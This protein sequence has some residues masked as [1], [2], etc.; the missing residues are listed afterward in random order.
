MKNLK[1]LPSLVPSL[2]VQ[3]LALSGLVA[4]MLVA[5]K[6]AQAFDFS[7]KYNGKEYIVGG[8]VTSV[9]KTPKILG[10]T[11]WYGNENAAIEFARAG[12]RRVANVNGPTLK[13]AYL[14]TD[15]SWRDPKNEWSAKGPSVYN[16]PKVGSSTIVILWASSN[17]NFNGGPDVITGETHFGLK[18]DCQIGPPTT[19]KYPLDDPS[20]NKCNAYTGFEAEDYYAFVPAA[21]PEPLTILGSITAAGFGV[22]FKRKK[23]STKEE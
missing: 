23:N 18:T 11:P 22:A 3:T 12:G 14:Q 9:A 6:P 19:N 17:Y 13:F 4:S 21:V 8:I 2:A 5:V 1:N 7:L 15:R 10:T 16:E 20:L